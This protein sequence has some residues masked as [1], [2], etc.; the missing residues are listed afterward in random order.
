MNAPK[1]ATVS[2]VFSQVIRE[3]DDWTCQVCGTSR[4]NIGG[5]SASHHIAK[6]MGSKLAVAWDLDN[7]TAKCEV[8][9]LHPNGCHK[10]MD[11]HPLHHTEWIRQHLGEARY[12]ALKDRSLNPPAMTPMLKI[13]I[14]T[15][16][17]ATL[18]DLRSRRATGETGLLLI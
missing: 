3:R 11:A 10:W 13:E 7:A 5:L 15:D 16:L 2:A 12:E 8:E 6:G 14:H 4:R 17:K 18:K 9:G 1:K